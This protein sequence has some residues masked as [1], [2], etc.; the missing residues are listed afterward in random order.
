MSVQVG[1]ALDANVSEGIAVKSS[2][3]TI[4]R[5]NGFVKKKFNFIGIES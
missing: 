3:K 5:C 1:C 4:A 2:A